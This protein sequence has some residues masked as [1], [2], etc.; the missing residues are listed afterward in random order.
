[1]NKKRTLYKLNLTPDIISP[2]FV[3]ALCSLKHYMQKGELMQKKGTL[4]FFCGKMGAGKSTKSKIIAL[5]KNA[6][7]VSEDIWLEAHYPNQINS[8]EEYVKFSLRIKPFVKL[9]VQQIL[10]SGTN[11]VMDFPANTCKQREW[12]KQLCSQIK[13]EHELIF[14]DVS[15]EQCLS[16]IAKR[17]KEQPQRAKFD[18]ETVFNHVTKFFEYPSENE[19]LN[20]IQI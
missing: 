12:F 20:I 11:V 15:D 8:F 6:V 16:H 14:L 10:K 4:T 3:A 17:R 2:T 13:C 7:L 18:T 19:R 5:K 9:H 1:V